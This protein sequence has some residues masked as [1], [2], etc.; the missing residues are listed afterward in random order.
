MFTIVLFSDENIVLTPWVIDE[1]NESNAI[2]LT[3]QELNK[4]SEKEVLF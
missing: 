3:Q 4:L 1:G 2:M